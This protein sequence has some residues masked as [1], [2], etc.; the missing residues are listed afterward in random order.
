MKLFLTQARNESN[1]QNLCEKILAR[2]SLIA[3]SLI[4]VKYKEKFK[5]W[6]D[7]SYAVDINEDESE[8]ETRVEEITALEFQPERY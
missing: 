6:P 3:D 4:S 1:S 5:E 7:Y 2:D 8:L